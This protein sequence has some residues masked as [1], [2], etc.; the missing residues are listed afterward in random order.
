MSTTIRNVYVYR[1]GQDVTAVATADLTARRFIAISGDRSGGNIA[2]APAGAGV[3]VFGVAAEDAATGELV[4]VARGGVVKVR[5][6]G[7][8]AAG[9]EVQAAAGGAAATKSTGIAVGIAVTGAA[10]GADAEIALDI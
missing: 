6:A 3:R 4:H 9:V 5:A 7:A 2:V 8:I 1:P 10:D